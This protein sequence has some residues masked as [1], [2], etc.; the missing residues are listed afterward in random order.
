[1]S[2]IEWTSLHAKF[3]KVI[4]ESF[5]DKKIRYFVL[6]NY[7][8][9]PEQNNAK[10]VDIVIEPNKYHEVSNILISAMHISDIQYYTITQFDRMRCWHIVDYRLKFAIHI[11]IIENEIYKGFEYFNFETLY[12]NTINYKGFTV[13]NK[14]MN[15][16]MLLV[17]NLVAY[18]S[19]KGKYC[20]TIKRNY[21][22]HKS[23]ID[24][25]LL[26]FWGEQTG[27]KM[28]KLLDD[29]DFDTII[30]M[31]HLWES[32]ALRRI[33]M[34]RPIYT[35]K[36]ILKFLLGKIYRIIWCP[37]QFQR[38]IAVEAPD[39]TG[40]TTFINHL[41]DA[42]QFYYVSD[43]ERFCIHHFRP[44]I[45]PNLGAVG[46]KAGVM[47]QD[48]DFTN[49]HRAKPTGFFSSIIRMI[50]YWIDYLIGVPYL[51]RKEVQY[52]QYTIFDRYIYDFIIDPKRSR[53][54]LP[55]WIRVLFAKMVKQPQILF[56]L[57]ADSETIYKRKQELTI[58]EIE[59]QLNAFSKLK[60]YN[61]NTV[62]IDANKSPA[63][64]VEQ[65]IEVI[66]ESF[67]HKK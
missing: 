16:V 39:G 46:E 29:D 66:F 6:R 67:F 53:I 40:K 41:I 59:R 27:Q 62:I 42:L 50:Y 43:R 63:E 44:S 32:T 12:A 20:Q 65:A 9:L 10:D 34:K 24:K 5:C 60:I 49:P 48:K 38:L 33:F 61:K 36:N 19:L 11:D 37:K 15:T 2:R 17:Q 14:A 3:L 58:P 21:V 28:T 52:A 23:D 18:K 13:L 54:N 64:M 47:K 8:E 25:Q 45:V 57:N 7:E 4:F 31:S 1:M 22:L 55:Q 56:I 30:K 35:I 51:L 26:V